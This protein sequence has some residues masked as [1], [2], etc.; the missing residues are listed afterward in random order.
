MII[1]NRD[2]MKMFEYGSHDMSDIL[3]Q[4]SKYGGPDDSGK[5]VRYTT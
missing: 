2:T 4:Y 5:K 3:T 1:Y